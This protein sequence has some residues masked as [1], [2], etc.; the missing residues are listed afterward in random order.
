V[1]CDAPPLLPVTDAAILAKE[2]SGAIVAVSAGR[3][4]RHQLAGAIEA[5]ATVGAKVAGVV[6]SM[7]PTRGPD[8]YYT[9]GYGYGYGYKEPEPK[10]QR[11]P[12]HPA[13]KRR[14]A[15]VAPAPYANASVEDLFGP[16]AA[17][18]DGTGPV[19]SRSGAAES[20]RTL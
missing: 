11:A 20:R 13:A 8:S 16:P 2:T 17:A 14:N 6:M 4:S 19:R 9:Y 3:T 18:H 10:K 15:P 1:L 5:L 12:K 7:V